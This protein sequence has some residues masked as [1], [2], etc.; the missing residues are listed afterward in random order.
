[1]T[2]FEEVPTAHAL[3]PTSSAIIAQKRVPLFVLGT[4][5]LLNE[6]LRDIRAPRLS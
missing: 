3:M 6:M 2:G 4:S 5:Y 1:M